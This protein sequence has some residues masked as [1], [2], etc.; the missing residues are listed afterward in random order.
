MKEKFYIKNMVCQRCIN[1]VKN[2]LENLGIEILEID[3]GYAVLKT[4]PDAIQ[5]DKIK[6]VLLT[7]GFELLDEKR[8]QIVEQINNVIIN[9][10]HHNN[11]DKREMEKY[12]DYLSRKLNLDYNYL[13]NLYSSIESITIEKF[14]ILQKIE[15]VK[16]LLVYDELSLGEI[17][18]NLCYS[19]V[20]HLSSQFKNITGLTP[21]QFKLNAGN[22]RKPLD[23][24]SNS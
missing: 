4:K 1:V 6:Q 8:S 11:S 7:N 9:Q 14:I 10:V 23:H 19:S 2:E 22:R 16:E 21:S 3:L 12:S 20:Q 15:K 5:L 24:L 13:S 18:F 17:A